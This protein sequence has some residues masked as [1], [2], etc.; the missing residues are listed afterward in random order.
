MKSSFSTALNSANS[1]I[2]NNIN[3]SLSNKNWGSLTSVSYSKFGD[4]QIGKNRKH[5]FDDWGL[6]KYFSFNSRDRDRELPT[7]NSNPNIQKN[8][9][10]D[11]FDIFQKFTLKLLKD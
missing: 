6:T 3:T 11:T 2:V 4:I 5:G 7:K 1:A 9:H 8:T 10:Y